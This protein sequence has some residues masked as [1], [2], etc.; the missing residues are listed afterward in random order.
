MP[1]E[2]KEARWVAV[3]ESVCGNH[4]GAYLEMRRVDLVDWF[5]DDGMVLLSRNL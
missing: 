1:F 3:F 5:M 2:R 4:D